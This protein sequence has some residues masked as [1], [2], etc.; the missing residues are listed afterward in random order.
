MGLVHGTLAEIPA[1]A[2]PEPKGP[3][4]T[5][6]TMTVTLNGN[7]SL[8][9]KWKCPNPAGTS[10][11]V[12]QVYRRVGGTGEFTYLGGSGAKLFV[13]ATVPA[14][15]TQLTYQIQAVRSTAIGLWATFNVNFGTNV[16]GGVTASVTEAVATTQAPKLAA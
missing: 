6:N 8:N 2:T 7:G 13:D 5:P 1:P 10:G 3:P 15:A 16:G 12:Y 14:G 11:T 4:G 9:L